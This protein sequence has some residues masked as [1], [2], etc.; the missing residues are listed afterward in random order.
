MNMIVRMGI[1]ASRRVQP[2]SAVEVETEVLVRGMTLA[3]NGGDEWSSFRLQHD[4]YAMKVQIS[5]AVASIRAGC[6]QDCITFCGPVDASL[7]G[8]RIAGNVDGCG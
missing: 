5:V 4:V 8:G 6:D 7:N 2:C 1:E 3:V